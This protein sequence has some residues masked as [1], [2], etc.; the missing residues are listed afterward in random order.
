MMS[1]GRQSCNS[2]KLS[3]GLD[4]ALV[5]EVRTDGQ[6]GSTWNVAPTGTL[7][8][9]MWDVRKKRSQKWFQIGEL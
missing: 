3:G 1:S 4:Q 5:P 2:G 8:H 9:L 7:M 6:S